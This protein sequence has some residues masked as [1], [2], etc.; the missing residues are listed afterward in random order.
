[1][2]KTSKSLFETIEYETKEKLRNIIIKE[3]EEWYGPKL[4]KYYTDDQELDHFYDEE[5]FESDLSKACKKY[6][7]NIECILEIIEEEEDGIFDEV[8]E[9]FQELKLNCKTWDELLD[10]ENLNPENQ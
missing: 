5:E 7:E 6:G 8:K 3:I 1:M 10:D 9:I 2:P 4:L